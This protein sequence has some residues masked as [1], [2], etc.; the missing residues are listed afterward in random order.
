MI[1]VSEDDNRVVVDPEVLQRIEDLAHVEI[2]LHH[3]VAVVADA[4]LPGKLFGTTGRT[5]RS[6]GI[7]GV[8]ATRAAAK[9]TVAPVSTNE[10]SGTLVQPRTGL[11]DRLVI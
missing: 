6:S 9:R 1:H 4:G 2:A 5:F 8:A 3:L 11:G 10:L 7:T